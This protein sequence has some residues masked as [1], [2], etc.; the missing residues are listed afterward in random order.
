VSL[1]SARIDL[2]AIQ[3]NVRTIQAA[4]G[5]PIWADVSADAHGHGAPAVARAAMDAGVAGLLVATVGEAVALREAGI[6][7]PLVAWQHPPG[8]GFERAAAFDVVPAVSTPTQL[9]AASAALPAVVLAAGLGAS[10]IG[11]PPEDWRDLVADAALRERGGGPHADA[12]LAFTPAGPFRSRRDPET[13]SVMAAGAAQARLAIAAAADAGLACAQAGPPEAGSPR[14]ARL[15]FGDSASAL[16]GGTGG[17]TG[18]D[19]DPVGIPIVGRA[20]YGL[21]PFSGEGAAELGLAPVMTVRAQVITTKTVDGGE[22][23]SYG[24]TYRT[25]GTS[26]LALVA[27]GYAHGIDRAASNRCTVWLN[28]R[29]YPVAGR[30]A[31]DVLVADLGSDTA[32][33][34]DEAVLFGSPAE[35]HPGVEEWAS[36]LGTTPDEVVTAIAPSVVRSY[37]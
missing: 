37:A 12:V 23:V 35:G 1:R 5:T 11:C 21:S 10:A 28:G 20:L 29:S 13:I 16:S 18:G 25:R 24:Y 31:M 19:A 15:L 9:A 17:A 3:H 33:V 4:C 27:I 30:V 2:R 7:A 6:A 14:A 34:G 26:T 22:G 8:E 32:D 36:A